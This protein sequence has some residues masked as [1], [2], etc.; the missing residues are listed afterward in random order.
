MSDALD[1]LPEAERALV[2][3]AAPPRGSDAMKAVLTD[4]R[5]SHPDWIYERKLDGIRCIAV[6][7]G[8][9]VRLLS[10]NDLSLDGRYPEL[11]E[12]LGSEPAERFAVDGEDF[13]TAQAFVAA[14]LGVSLIPQLG[15]TA[16]HPNVA[17]RPLRNP[18]PIRTISAA[19]RETSAAQ[20][21][22]QGFL[23]ALRPGR[24]A[25]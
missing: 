11:V 21:A 25:I 7:D 9:A 14:G 1:T 19:V 17:V 23:D 24:R 10:R 18:E 2:R 22:L 13:S 6:R 20:P 4:E 16:A 3:K 15:L 8:G 5:F 12:A